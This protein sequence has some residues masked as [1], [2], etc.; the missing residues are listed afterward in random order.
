[1]SSIPLL[2]FIS[3]PNQSNPKEDIQWESENQPAIP[4]HSIYSRKRHPIHSS[5]EIDNTNPLEN[6][7][8]LDFLETNLDSLLE[9]LKKAQISNENELYGVIET[10]IQQYQSQ[11]NDQLMTIVGIAFYNELAIAMVCPFEYSIICLARV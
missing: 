8:V 10:I 9:E 7:Q 5:H 4:N 1:M 6:K 2:D 3:I 11:D